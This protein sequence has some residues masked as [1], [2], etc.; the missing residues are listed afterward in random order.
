MDEEKKGWRS[1]EEKDEWMRR[2][3]NGCG[4]G[5]M[6]EENEERMSCRENG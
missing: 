6:D 3:K 5:R 2:M 4:E 1:E